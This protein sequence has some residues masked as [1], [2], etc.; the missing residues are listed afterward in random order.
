MDVPTRQSYV[1]SLV[2]PGERSFA[3]AVTNVARNVGWA[4]G[5]AV[6]GALMQVFAFSAPLIVGGCT[7]IVYDLLLY[8][9]FCRVR[10]P[11]E[12]GFI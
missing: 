10:A 5:S 6:G 2:A 9:S 12:T 8:R 7:K 11:E 4:I 1:A 3:S